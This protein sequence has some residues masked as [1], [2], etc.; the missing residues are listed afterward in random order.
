MV[1]VGEWVRALGDGVGDGSW[2]LLNYTP[3]IYIF[4]FSSI[5]IR[6]RRARNLNQEPDDYQSV[7]FQ[8]D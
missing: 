8:L 5:F 4:D 3:D 7:K 2:M 1:R 6:S